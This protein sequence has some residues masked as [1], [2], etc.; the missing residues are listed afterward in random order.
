MRHFGSAHVAFL[1]AMMRRRTGAIWGV[2]RLKVTPLRCA[3]ASLDSC[4]GAARGWACSAAPETKRREIS[5]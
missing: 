3:Y 2:E 4:S 1:I 5:W